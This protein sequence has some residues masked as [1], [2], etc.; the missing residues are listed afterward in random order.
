MWGARIAALTRVGYTASI[1]E[2][3]ARRIV[4]R[5]GVRQIL[6]R[7]LRLTGR[8][9]HFQAR[10]N[11]LR[12]RATFIAVTGSSGKSTVT[13]M[14]A[15][16]LARVAPTCGQIM[17]NTLRTC[18]K[19]L[20]RLSPEH[21]YVVCEI[22]TGGPG[23]LQPQINLIRPSVGVVT[24]V[25]L[26]H[27]SAFRSLE[28]VAEEKAKLVEALP[29]SGLAILNHDDPRVSAMAASTR[30]RV[31]TFGASGG[32][33]RITRTV[34]STP[35]KLT[36]TITHKGES[37]EVQTGLTGAHNSVPALAA[38]ACAHQL[39]VP[40]AD[41]QEGLRRFKPLFGRCSVHVFDNG[42]IFIAD[43]NKGAYWSFYLPIEMMAKFSAA[44][45]R[46]V[47]GQISDAG[48][49]NPKYRD[50]YRAARQVADQVIFVGDNAHRSKATPADIASERFV[51]KRTVQEAAEFVRR[52][53]IADEI[54][55]LKSAPNIHLERIL[56]GFDRDI[57]C[58]EHACGKRRQCLG[59]DRLGVP[60]AR[61]HYAGSPA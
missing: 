6:K 1:G 47:I 53:A 13:A 56:L 17:K 18:I 3:L 38:F 10:L 5:S 19:T 28:A 54:I 43:T 41:I 23:Q 35:G 2:R 14:L 45:K 44:R 8:I 58:W 49:T 59:C 26:E 51:E 61:F 29:R 34:A 24:L 21:R 60:P 16:I 48:N 15:Q 7:R 20:I 32:D 50:V 12:S 42:P 57:R 9:R 52:T 22:G 27:Y 39:G 31:V 37:F 55:L 33:Y 30:A 11:R 46:I 40:I 36:L 4:K 25:G